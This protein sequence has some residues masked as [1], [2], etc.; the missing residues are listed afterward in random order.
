[1]KPITIAKNT[2][3][4]LLDAAKRATNQATLNNRTVIFQDGNYSCLVYPYDIIGNVIK[5]IKKIALMIEIANLEA[6]IAGK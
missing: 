6:R 2:K 5:A 3:E 1:M 4:T